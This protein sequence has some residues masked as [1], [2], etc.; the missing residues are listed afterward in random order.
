MGMAIGLKRNIVD[1]SLL[2]FVE[3]IYQIWYIGHDKT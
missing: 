1:L 2:T 3:K